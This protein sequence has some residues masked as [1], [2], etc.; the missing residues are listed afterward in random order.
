MHMNCQ[1]ADFGHADLMPADGAP[2]YTKD[3]GTP[4]YKAPEL[5][6]A[7]TQG[8]RLVVSSEPRH[9][10]SSLCVQFNLLLA[11]GSISALLLVKYI[12]KRWSVHT[13]LVTGDGF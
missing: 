7:W 12:P 6:K 5:A 13:V 4:G 3:C 1:I 11:C 9:D 8:H 10:V 2:L